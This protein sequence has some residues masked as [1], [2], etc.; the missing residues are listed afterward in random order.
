MKK[1]VKKRKYKKVAFM[2]SSKQMKSLLNY[3]K[4]R[5]TTPIKLIKKRIRT[6]TENF[7]ESVPDKYFVKHTQLD[8]FDDKTENNSTETK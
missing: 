6:S 7:A 5:G 4:A 3:C 1:K 2:L 8:L